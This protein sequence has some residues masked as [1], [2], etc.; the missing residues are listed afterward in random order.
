MGG[1]EASARHPHRRGAGLDLHRASAL[2]ELRARFADVLAV[3]KKER[4]EQI[5]DIRSP[6]EFSGKIIAPAGIQE[7]AIRAGHIPG[8]VNIPWAKA[9]NPDGTLKSKE[10]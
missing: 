6:D 5:L 1:R 4:D 10:E 9:V 8:S 7:L 3:A 2:G